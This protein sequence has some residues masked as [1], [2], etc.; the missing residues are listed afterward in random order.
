M[1][2]KSPLAF[3]VGSGDCCRDARLQIALDPLPKSVFIRNGVQIVILSAL[4]LV[5]CEAVLPVSIR[6]YLAISRFHHEKLLCIGAI[7]CVY[8][9]P[10][11]K[12]MHCK[13]SGK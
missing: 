3:V 6:S 5:G 12:E 4:P 8:F 9:F 11:L 2:V 7:K 1:K 13:D 10:S